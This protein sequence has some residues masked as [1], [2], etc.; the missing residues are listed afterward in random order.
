MSAEA[1]EAPTPLHRPLECLILRLIV[2]PELLK[3]STLESALIND[4]LDELATDLCKR[5]SDL[6]A[7][8]VL[9][10]HFK[11]EVHEV[12]ENSSRSVRYMSSDTHRSTIIMMSSPRRAKSDFLSLLM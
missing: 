5:V 3:L 10:H 11:L 12:E 4:T 7:R 2:F 9:Q 1:F 6:P 8:V